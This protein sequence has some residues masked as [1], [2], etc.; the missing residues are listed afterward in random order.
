MPPT[1]RPARPP[2]PLLPHALLMAG[3]GIVA[4]LVA[5]IKVAS[6]LHVD[7]QISWTG[8]SLVGAVLVCAGAGLAATSGERVF[9][10][11]LQRLGAA[12]AVN[13]PSATTNGTGPLPPTGLVATETM[14]RY[15]RPGCPLTAGKPVVPASQVD[16]QRAG[17]LPCGVCG[18]GATS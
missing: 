8:L 5:W 12:L 16:H 18:A 7:R 4:M 13:D 11:H 17:R 10:L 9:L 2:R 1:P 15:H 6:S 3:S 14:S